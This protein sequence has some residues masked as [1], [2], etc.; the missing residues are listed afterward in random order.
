VTAAAAAAVAASGERVQQN[1][2]KAEL[3][4]EKAM[5]Q[6]VCWQL[7]FPLMCL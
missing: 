1:K 5:D 6:K 7:A 4:Y 2:T 3:D